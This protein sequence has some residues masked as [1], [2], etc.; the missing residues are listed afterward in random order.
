MDAMLGIP[1]SNIAKVRVSNSVP[2]SFDN[3]C[4]LWINLFSK[5]DV[6]LPHK[7]F[8]LDLLKRAKG[9]FSVRSVFGHSAFNKFVANDPLTGSFVSR[10]HKSGKVIQSVYELTLPQL[11]ETLNVIGGLKLGLLP[12]SLHQIS[13]QSPPKANGRPH[14]PRGAHKRRVSDNRH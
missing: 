4:E 13:V 8:A 12:L 5:V 10:R 11:I 1:G 3:R 7:D 6:F 9:P 2:T 14:R